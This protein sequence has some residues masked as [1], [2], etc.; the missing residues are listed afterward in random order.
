M[1]TAKTIPIRSTEDLIR[2]G[3]GLKQ[4]IDQMTAKLRD[5]NKEL[6]SLAEFK[7]GGKTGHLVGAGYKVRV[8]LKENVTWDQDKLRQ[9]REHMPAEQFDKLFRMLFDPASKK[10]IDGFLEK[11]D[12][13]LAQGIRWAMQVKA[14]TPQ[15]TY[16]PMEE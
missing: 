16:E 5:I 4:G 13:D 1:N 10:L 11:G 8:Q 12:R 14:G 6:A 2:E 15:V 7:N 3:A 9:L